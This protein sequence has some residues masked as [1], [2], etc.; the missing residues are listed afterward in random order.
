MNINKIIEGL[1]FSIDMML[2]NPMTGQYKDPNELNE[3]DRI[4]YEAYSEAI[5]ELKKI[6]YCK[7]CKHRP[8]DN[9]TKERPTGFNIE[10]PDYKC[11][12]Q[13][14][15]GYYSWY[16]DDNWFCGNGEPKDE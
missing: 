4:S 9:R 15:D 7:D 14:D 11:P 6:V 2:F 10:F 5:E 16:P 12:C 13:C 3:D 1:H 8:I